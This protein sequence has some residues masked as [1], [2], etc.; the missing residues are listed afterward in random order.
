MMGVSCMPYDLKRYHESKQSHF[1]TFSCY[2]R[3][4]YLAE[5]RVCAVFVNS[6][7]RMR[8][9]Y[10][11]RVYGYVLMP[12]HVHL[13]LSEPQSASLARAVQALKVSVARHVRDLNTP[14]WQKRYYDHNVRSYENFMNKLRYIHRNPMKRGLCATP[15]D[16]VWSSFRHYAT[17]EVGPVEIESEWTAGRRIGRIPRLLGQKN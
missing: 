17:V 7:E 9:K 3:L 8:R 14:L 6:L 1:V 11:F 10:Q 15:E 2:H 4:P 16:W 12:E 13:L 5:Q